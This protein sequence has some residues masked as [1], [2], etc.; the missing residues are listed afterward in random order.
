[1]EE[2]YNFAPA[3][4]V[5]HPAALHISA[6][7]EK[8]TLLFQGATWTDVAYPFLKLTTQHKVAILYRE[9]EEGSGSISTMTQVISLQLYLIEKSARYQL[10]RMLGGTQSRS[11]PQ[12]MILDKGYRMYRCVQE[13]NSEILS[14]VHV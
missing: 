8:V 14:E 4:Y 9:F 10:N 6:S 12:K 3:S 5:L 7:N 2:N 1:M 11:G 13:C